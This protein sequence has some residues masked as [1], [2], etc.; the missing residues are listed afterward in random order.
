MAKSL[1]EPRLASHTPPLLLTRALATDPHA[2]LALKAKAAVLRAQGHFDEAIMVTG[3]SYQ[4]LF[5]RLKDGL[6][7][8]GMPEQAEGP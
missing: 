7:S 2:L 8:A 6:R 1:R 5:E 4:Q 3:P